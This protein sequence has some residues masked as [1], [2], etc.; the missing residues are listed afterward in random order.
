[1]RC[2]LCGTEDPELFH[3]KPRTWCVPCTR[4][5]NLKRYNNQSEEQR[6]KHRLSA[7]KSW[8]KK[9]Y[10]LTLEDYDAMYAA[11][12]GCCKICNTEVTHSGPDRYKVACVDHCHVTLKVRGLLCWDCNVGLGKFHDSRLKLAAAIKYLEDSK[13]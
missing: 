8:L 7:R 2:S 1:M 9:A 6:H 4:A 13:C 12:G 10:G 3:K 11:Q 5:D